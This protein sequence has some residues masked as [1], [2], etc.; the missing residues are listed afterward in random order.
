MT[1]GMNEVGNKAEDGREQRSKQTGC[2]E[3]TDKPQPGGLQKFRVAG[4]S[5]RR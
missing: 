4:R 3:N 1:V 5:L 2:D